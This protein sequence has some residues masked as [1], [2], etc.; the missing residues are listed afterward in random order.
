MTPGGRL[1]TTTCWPRLA[2]SP[3]PI[4]RAMKS[5][6]PPMLDITMR[7]GRFGKSSARTPYGITTLTMM[8]NVNVATHEADMC[9]PLEEILGALP[10]TTLS[11]AHEIAL[12]R[13]AVR[14]GPG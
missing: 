1:S 13:I 3:C 11:A 14:T 6:E 4:T 10:R 8:D 9:S 7:M 2:V 12:G 5:L